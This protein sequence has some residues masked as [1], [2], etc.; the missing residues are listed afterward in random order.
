MYE[1]RLFDRR[2]RGDE[3]DLQSLGR[4][5]QFDGYLGRRGLRV[6]AHLSLAFKGVDD[7]LDIFIPGD[8]FAEDI[9]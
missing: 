3:F 2:L 1:E 9:A 8:I 7:L 6:V 4:F 5:E